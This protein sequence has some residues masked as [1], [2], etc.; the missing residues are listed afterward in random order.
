MNILILYGYLGYPMRASL[1]D[2][3]YSFKN[4]SSANCFYFTPDQGNFPEYLKKINFDLVVYTTSLISERWR[5]AETF[6]TL[7][8]D[9]IH[10][11]KNI[12]CVKVV[13]PQDE[14]IHTDILNEFVNEF[15]INYVYTVAPESEWKKIYKQVD[16]TKV[17][18]TQ[19]L[20]GYLEDSTIKKVNKIVSNTTIQNI[21]IGYR[22]FRSPPWLGSHGFLKTKI[23]DVFN[24]KAP[25][26]GFKADISTNEKDTI[27]GDD[28]F[29]F[30]A[31]CKYF[32]GVEG[33]STVI[34]PQGKIWQ[35]GT[36]YEKLH[37][38][39]SFSDFE[40]NCFPGMDGNLG[41]IAISPRQLEAVTAKSCQVLIE[42]NYNGILKPGI[43][44]IEIKKDFSNLNEVFQKMKDESLR[45]KI[46]ET[47]YYDIVL[48]GKYS[49]KTYTKLI[50]E[51]SLK[52]IPLKNKKLLDSFYLLKNNMADKTYWS[53]KQSHSEPNA[54]TSRNVFNKLYKYSGLR[55]V[56]NSLIK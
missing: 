20:T 32:I 46:V 28:W 42:G 9:K 50:T 53:K 27:A 15:K 26:A 48:S 23:A 10:Y 36:D 19:V 11:L 40:T 44:Y 18:F 39:A 1:R 54:F 37:P 5:G 30:M 22:A 41:L 55:K 17:K 7:V 3:I 47:A 43:H 13:H 4:N 24:E 56:K 33:G 45:I 29:K 51:N 2:L 52:N 49:Y 34:D 31:R 38:N 25:A 8:T 21:D 14:W 6:K 12:D 16:F 35:N